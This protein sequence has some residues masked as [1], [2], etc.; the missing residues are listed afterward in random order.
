MQIDFND[1]QPRKAFSPRK[2]SRLPDSNVTPERDL[3]KEKQEADIVSTD[4]GMQMN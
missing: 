3:Q 2:E 1:E 4:D